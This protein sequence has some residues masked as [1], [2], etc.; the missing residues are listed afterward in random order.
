[1]KHQH[2][3]VGII[4]QLLSARLRIFFFIRQM[5]LVFNIKRIFVEKNC[6]I[7]IGKMSKFNVKI[8]KVKGQCHQGQN[9]IYDEKHLKNLFLLLFVKLT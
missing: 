9:P 4:P 1:M 3:Y 2:K 7:K 5:S 6:F 8:F